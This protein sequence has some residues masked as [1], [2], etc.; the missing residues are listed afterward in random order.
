MWV[1]SCVKTSSQPVAAAADKIGRRRCGG[2][3]EDGVVRQRRRPAIREFGLVGEDDMR[4]SRRRIE[5][6]APAAAAM[7]SSAMTR[8]GRRPLFAAMEVDDEVR[9]RQ[10]PKAERRVEE[11]RGA[12]RSVRR[13]SARSSRRQRYVACRRRAT[14][15]RNTKSA[16]GE[17]R[18]PVSDRCATATLRLC[19]RLMYGTSRGDDALHLAVEREASRLVSRRAGLVEQR[20]HLGIAVV[21]AVEAGRRHLRGM[22][23]A[24]QDVRVGERAAGPLQREQ[25]EVAADARRRTAWRTRRCARRASMPTCAQVLLN[26]GRLQPIELDVRRPSASARAAA[27]ARRRRDRG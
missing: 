8:G 13:Q 3:H 25:L 27:R 19:Q 2:R 1:N 4:P 5:P 16:S 26:D 23:H 21:A 12:E 24:P 22:E 11:R 20:V 7:S 6:A 15:S 10:R 17:M 9:G 14:I 18:M